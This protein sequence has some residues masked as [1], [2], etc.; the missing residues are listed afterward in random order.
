MYAFEQKLATEVLSTNPP[1]LGPKEKFKI[2]TQPG[3]EPEN[4]ACEAATLL[5]R[6]IGSHSY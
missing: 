1:N 3:T 6:H 5:L 2:L 4:A